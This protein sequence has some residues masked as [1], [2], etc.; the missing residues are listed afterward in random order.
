MFDLVRKMKHSFLS[1]FILEKTFA[2]NSPNRQQN[3]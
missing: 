1:L 3:G 2:K